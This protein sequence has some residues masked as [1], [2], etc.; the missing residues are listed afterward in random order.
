MGTTKVALLEDAVG[1]FGFGQTR[2]AEST[3]LESA[4]A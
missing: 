2:V 1:D 3:P 4:A